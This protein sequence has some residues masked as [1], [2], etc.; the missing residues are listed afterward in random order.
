[1]TLSDF[2]AIAGLISSVAVLVSLVYLGLQVRQADRNQQAS[3][4]QNRSSRVVEIVL[5]AT[6]ASIAEAVSKGLAGAQDM[7]GTQLVQF[8]SYC[9]GVF[10]AAEDDFYQH[11]EG[12]LSDDAFASYL[13]GVK[14]SFVSPGMRVAWMRQRNAYGKE[15]VAF[16]DKI[17]AETPVAI[18]ADPVARWNK[19]IAAEKAKVAD[20]LTGA[21]AI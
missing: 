21:G 2:A 18:P 15:F 3:I 20:R 1:M 12:L 17:V 13:N 16:M 5:S 8:S 6:D 7:S 14:A 19:D 10:Y 11:R 9:R 4:R